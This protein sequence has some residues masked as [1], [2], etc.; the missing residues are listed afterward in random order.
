M[1]TERSHTRW[2][3]GLEG[4]ERL[5]QLF[6]LA[7]YEPDMTVTTLASGDTIRL[8]SHDIPKLGLRLVPPDDRAT[9]DKAI[10]DTGWGDD[11]D[12]IKVVLIAEDR[13]LKER[14]FLTGTP[15]DPTEAL[16]ELTIATVSGPRPP[17]LQN[18]FGGFEVQLVFVLNRDLDHRIARRPHRKGTI[19][20]RAAW[21]VRGERDAGGLE[22]L[23]LLEAKRR[24]EGLPA[25]T[26]LFVEPPDDL[27]N[28]DHLGGLSI[29]I[30]EGLYKRLAQARGAERTAVLQ[31]LS[32]D[33]MCQL[34]YLAAAQVEPGVDIDVDASA[35]LRLLHRRVVAGGARMNKDQF[36]HKLRHEPHCLVAVLSGL[37]GQA[38]RLLK[39]FDDN[40][41]PEEDA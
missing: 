17:A 11:V 39:M 34:V 29:Y 40:E 26:L 21:E 32:N 28:A 20:A 7:V 6:T 9:L 2:F 33:A 13:F 38:N 19:L 35:A 25:G 30:H 41:G 27:L 37:E 22:P 4:L 23:P 8:A 5:A 14:Q 18:P 24:D 12:A 16:E 1:S 36:A 31:Q 10:R 15:L 3:T